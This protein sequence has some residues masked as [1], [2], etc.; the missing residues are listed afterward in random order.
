MF[1]RLLTTPLHEVIEANVT[2]IV[3]ICK[4]NINNKS[5]INIYNCWWLMTGTEISNVKAKSSEVPSCCLECFFH[6]FMNIPWI[7]LDVI[8][9]YKKCHSKL[10]REKYMCKNK[11]NLV[12]GNADNEKNLHQGCR[13]FIF[14]NQF[15]W[16]FKIKVTFTELVYH[17]I[18]L[19]KKHLLCKERKTSIHSNKLP[20]G[21]PP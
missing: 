11:N 17:S 1:D 3:E 20:S 7:R 21:K 13:K 6:L 2:K 16:I 5:L 4:T 19:L 15:N 8:Y 12:S 14:F 18:S 9:K 10:M